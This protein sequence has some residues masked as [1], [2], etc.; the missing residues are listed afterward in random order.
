MLIEMHEAIPE[1]TMV[2]EQ[3]LL[4]S[5]EADAQFDR[6]EVWSDD[7]WRL[8]VSLDAEV[9]GFSYLEPKRHIP[10]VEDLDGAEAE[11]FGKILALTSGVLKEVTGARRVFLYA[12]GGLI[13]H[14]HFFLVPVRPGDPVLAQIIEGEVE[15]ERRVG[16]AVRWGSTLVP[17]VAREELRSVATLIKENLATS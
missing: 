8:T 11:T 17:K 13:A 16:G 3:C 7:L 6:T 9:S 12:F 15:K 10:H 14:L 1:V 5:Q 2:V 4:C